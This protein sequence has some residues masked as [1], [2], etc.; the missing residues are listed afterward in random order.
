[1]S[2]IN[3]NKSL[4]QAFGALFG[5]I[6]TTASAVS[7]SVNAAGNLFEELEQRSASRLRTVS[8][9]IFYAEQEKAAR[10]MTESGLRTSEFMLETARKLNANPELSK[11]YA[12]VMK[13]LE[14]KLAIRKGLQAGPTAEAA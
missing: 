3:T 9:E 2:N 14:I 13:D 7:T 8:D 12:A 5:T 11:T 1:M 4:S 6:A 10:Q